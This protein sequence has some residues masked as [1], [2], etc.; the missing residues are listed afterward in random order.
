VGQ[1][2]GLFLKDFPFFP[3]GWSF[4]AD[5]KRQSEHGLTWGNNAVK[6]SGL[7]AGEHQRRALR[8][9]GALS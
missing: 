3:S 8:M 6:P 4:Q 2:R 7:V 9:V 5:A 1:K